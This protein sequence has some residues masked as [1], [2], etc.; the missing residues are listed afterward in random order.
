MG[1]GGTRDYACT[2]HESCI[3]HTDETAFEPLHLPFPFFNFFSFQRLNNWREEGNSSSRKVIEN[4]IVAFRRSILFFSFFFCLSLL[5]RLFQ[6]FLF[7]QTRLNLCEVMRMK[8]FEFNY[9]GEFYICF[10][11]FVT[12]ATLVTE[13][14]YMTFCGLTFRCEI[15]RSLRG[16]LRANNAIW[17]KRKISFLSLIFILLLYKLFRRWYFDEA[18]RC[19]NYARSTIGITR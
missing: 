7:E 4:L 13:F 16:A 6:P 11:F 15:A 5:P 12:E 14:F 8:C 19:N 2:P 10:F 3:L 17:K 18:C 1:E 9:I